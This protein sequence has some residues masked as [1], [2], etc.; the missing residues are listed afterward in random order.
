[1]TG[2]QTCALPI[3]NI[4]EKFLSE[5][6][7]TNARI[8]QGDLL[9]LI[10]ISSILISILSTTILDALCFGKPVIRVKFGTGEPILPY[11][12]CEVVLST[13]LK[14]LTYNID[15]I[16]RDETLQQRL[17]QN[18]STFIKDQCNIPPENPIQILENIIQNSEDL[19]L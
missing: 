10:S 2:V 14:E 3:F 16:L 6:H 4:Y 9:E 11:D 18:C 13:T 5:S 12:D 8:I 19:T 7:F 17:L 15:R 1:M